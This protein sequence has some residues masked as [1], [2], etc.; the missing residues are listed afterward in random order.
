MTESPNLL[1]DS[2]LIDRVADKENWT[3]AD[4]ASWERAKTAAKG[5]GVTTI[6][7]V[8]QEPDEHT[9][10]DVGPPWQSQALTAV[11]APTLEA[12]HQA[13]RRLGATG[14]DLPIE[15]PEKQT[16]KERLANWTIRKQPYQR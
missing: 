3:A 4:W 1:T 16:M 2:D 9:G 11:H 10:V 13:L 15:V 14:T 5:I 6:N 8:P 7:L 12:V